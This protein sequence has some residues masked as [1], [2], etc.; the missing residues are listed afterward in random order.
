[1]P[2]HRQIR[3]VDLQREA[4]LDD[5][6]V[7]DRQ[8]LAQRVDVVAQIGVVLVL[9]RRRDNPGRR[10]GHER[11]CRRLSQTV[12]M[13]P[14]PRALVFDRHR[15]LVGDIAHGLRRGHQTD[16]LAGRSHAQD[17]LQKIRI[18]QH[19]AHRHP[20]PAPAEPGHAMLHIGE[21]ALTP[22]F[23]VVENI[24]PGLHLPSDDMR[25]RRLDLL[26]QA[27]RVDL[28]PTRL[29]RKHRNE[30][31]RPRQAAGVRGQQSLG[32]HPVTPMG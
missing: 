9:H 31:L 11:A 2:L 1:M 16:A 5:R 18:V 19:V 24:D 14:Q 28:F 26:A 3:R 23:T 20:R 6:P 17:E 32:S 27:R 21:E 4:A 13:A 29:R 25:R 15:I 30:S 12:N 7:L 10:R 8:R 22:H